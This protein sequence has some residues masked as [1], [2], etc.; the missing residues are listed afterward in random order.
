MTKR[1]FIIVFILFSV[2]T[3]AQERTSS[4]YSFYGLGLNTFGGTVENKTMGGLSIFS[5][6]IHVNLQNP[7]AYG[8]L[9]LTTYTIG[10]SNVN[11]NI[12]SDS[13]SG[14]SNTSS[15][16]Y[17]AIGIPAGKLGF[18]FGLI[19]YSAVGYNIIDINES[20]LRAN[21]YSGKG[22]LNRV[23]LSAGYAVTENISLGIDVNYNFG[24]I[25][26]KNILIREG[27]QF[28][29]REI[30]RSDLSGLSYKIGLDYERMLSESLQL[31]MGAHYTPETKISSENKRE[32]ST[33]L[34]GPEGQEI[35][36]DARDIALEDTELTMPASFSLGAG[37]GKPRKWFLGAEYT[38]TEAGDFSNR[39][40][41]LEGASYE[42]ASKYR[43]GG[44]YI[45]NY[46]SLTSYFNRIV[47][48]GGLR[49][50]ET[51]LGLNGEAVNEFGIAFGLGLPAGRFMENINL[52][53]E[54][55]QRGT[56]NSGLIQENF[57]TAM[58]SLS[59]NDR[60]FVKRKFE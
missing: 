8:R 22:G 34:F 41:E 29:T 58:I 49:Y 47:Y 37:I 23:F 30:N 19:P 46:N 10:V 14:S 13:D 55:G 45:P 38:S 31:K 21:R 54:Y 16:D 2:I 28:G 26:N 33:L 15:L 9:K 3:T 27:L 48:R 56:T 24:N 51:G 4:P 50:E 36:V 11:V 7:A 25:Q 12:K 20:E 44:F 43:I 17:L 59:L 52:G 35:S 60:W 39:S 53:I 40:F 32:L 6:S 42:A 18:G 57:F 5:D 1:F